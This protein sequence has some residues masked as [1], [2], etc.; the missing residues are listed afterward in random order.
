LIDT[1]QPKP[2]QVWA[3]FH[4]TVHTLLPWHREFFLG[5]TAQSLE[6]EY[7]DMLESAPGFPAAVRIPQI[8][9]AV[10]GGREYQGR[11]ADAR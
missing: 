6:H 4:D 7:Q 5:D 3:S 8:M 9:T 11:G 1:S 10:W 2:K